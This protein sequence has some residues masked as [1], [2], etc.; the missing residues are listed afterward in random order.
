M[1]MF[2]KKEITKAT[3]V[4]AQTL[5]EKNIRQNIYLILI[6]AASLI[7]KYD[8]KRATHDIDIMDTGL[9][10]N[11]IGG[12]GALLSRLGYHV[13]SDALVNLHPDYLD[14]VEPITRKNN[15]IVLSLSAYDLAISKISRGLQRD[16]DDLM[17]SHV[18]AGVQIK[19][20]ERLYTEAASYWI[21][22]PVTFR[23]NWD[24]FRDEYKKRQDQ[25]PGQT[26]SPG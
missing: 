2:S 11:R 7:I 12:L 5:R 16:I 6:G 21:G 14:R 18:L 25:I 22:N 19:E 8:L 13:V 20:L 23:S 15:I 4:L 10:R 1:N 3:D 26:D 9:P 24:M 17:S